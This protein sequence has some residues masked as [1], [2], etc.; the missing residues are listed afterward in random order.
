MVTVFSKW[1]KELSNQSLRAT[2]SVLSKGR[3]LNLPTDILLDLYHR[4]VAPVFTDGS[5]IWGL[6][7][8]DAR[9]CI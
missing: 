5:K 2:Y 8:N 4:M 3:A 1:T 6:E 9:E 7:N